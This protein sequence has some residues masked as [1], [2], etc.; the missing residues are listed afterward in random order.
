MI[1]IHR[2][3]FVAAL[4]F[5]LQQG[6]NPTSEKKGYKDVQRVL[7]MLALRRNRHTITAI[8]LF[9]NILYLF[10]KN[11]FMSASTLAFR[12]SKLQQAV[13]RLRW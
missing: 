12:P 7:T 6:L 10:L 2:C 3:L 4:I 9:I 11:Y 13:P 1:D 8:V 5:L